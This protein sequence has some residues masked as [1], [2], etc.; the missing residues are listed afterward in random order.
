MNEKEK[1]PQLILRTDGTYKILIED[2][3]NVSFS[4]KE[5]IEDFTNNKNFI[6]IGGYRDPSLV[7]DD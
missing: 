5:S 6:I 1:Y 3:V 4:T 7:Y 2:G